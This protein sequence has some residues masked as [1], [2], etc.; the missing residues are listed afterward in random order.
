MKINYKHFI[1][2]FAA[3]FLSLASGAQTAT[4][5]GSTACPGGVL[6]LTSTPQPIHIV[7]QQAGI[8]IST[9]SPTYASSATTVAGTGSLGSGADSF[10]VPAGV[11]VDAGGNI[12]VA[13]YG[14]HRIQK[15]A[16]GATSGTTVAGTGTAG[17]GANQ[18][19]N[20]GGVY[21]DAGGNIFVADW[22]NHRIQKWAPGA[23]S[24]TTVAGTG[25]AGSGANQ[26]QRPFGVYVDAGGNIFVADQFN[27]RIQKWA[28]GATSGTT[29]AGTGT[30]GLGANQLNNPTGIYVDAGGNIY[31]ADEQNHRIQ[32]WAP[33]AT[34]GT[35]VAGT[36]TAGSA[37]NQLN[38]SFRVY[39][40]AGSN[41]YVADYF[42]NRIQKWAPG[43]TSGATVAGTGT[44][45]SAANQLASPTGVYVDAGGNI[46]VADRQNHRIQKFAASIVNT[47]TPATAGSYAALVTTQ[48]GAVTTNT[49]TVNAT[50]NANA[51]TPVICLSQV[52]SIAILTNDASG[53]T[54]SSSD[55]AKAIVSPETGVVRGKGAGTVVI[56]YR[57][58]PTCFRTTVVTINPP[59]SAITGVLNVCPGATTTLS[60]A[61]LGGTWSSND[62]TMAKVNP[63]TGLVT[64]FTSGTTAVT[65]LVS[66]GC[67]STANVNMPAG[68]LFIV[69]P[70]TICQGAM[71]TMSS[72]PVGGTWS[73]SHPSRASVNVT[74]GIVT[75]ISVGSATITYRISSGCFRTKSVTVNNITASITGTAN[76]CPGA[77]TDLTHVI[78]GGTWTSSNNAT[79]TVNATN[80]LVTGISGGTAVI[81]YFTSLGCYKTTVQTVFTA[82][83]NISGIATVC[84]G[85][86]TTLAS[87]PSGGIWSSSN[88]TAATVSTT[89]NVRGLAPGNTTIQY[90]LSSGCLVTREIT[91]NA[92]PDTITGSLAVCAGS[93]NSL[94]VSP[95]GGAWTSSNLS[96]ASIDAVSG[97]LAGISQGTANITYMLSSGCFRNATAI[98]NPQPGVITG[99]ATVAQGAFV[100]FTSSPAGGLWSSLASTTA[101]VNAATGRVTGVSTG[102]TTITYQLG[103]GCYRTRDI[104]VTGA[105]GTIE[106][107]ESETGYG[108]YFQLS[109]NPT[110]GALA[111]FSSVSGVFSVHT[112]DGKLVISQMIDQQATTILLPANLAPGMYICRFVGS[113]GKSVAQRLVVEK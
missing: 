109:P 35:T 22:A 78:T 10:R 102:F 99:A 25:T 14:N 5:A 56:T 91:V 45:G 86:Q 12:Y 112:I 52:L 113:D 66:A 28:P 18:L 107:P 24:G 60:N 94:S 1:S 58:N 62:T 3:L 96:K 13:D 89:G 26:L 79:A 87:W 85:F 38:G 65:Y 73:S 34:S 6:T 41:I 108:S 7:W 51:G 55:V 43:A 98:V 70:D 81:S 36:G 75:G 17:P 106:N 111:L 105:R 77:T 9:V 40:D 90:L 69:G 42:N 27:H 101:S 57:M 21:V 8:G 110:S 83:A 19:R 100:N 32:K 16:P 31:V 46:Y 64:G 72:G 4:I 95:S 59:V 104:T 33:G 39:V 93:E 80:G 37:A 61:T 23:G 82:P 50:I 92:I 71:A 48:V 76:I 84:E 20:P 68:P 47:Y 54:W 53:G 63:A 29:V 15:W 97:V 88:N 30:S 11:C 67:Y 49:L 2:C 44:A 74:T 103:T